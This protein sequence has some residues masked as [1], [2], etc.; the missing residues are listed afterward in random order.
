VIRLDL[1]PE[2]GKFPT[3]RHHPVPFVALFPVDER[4]ERMHWPP[5]ILGKGRGKP[6]PRLPELKFLESFFAIFCLS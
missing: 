5:L 3:H 4:E 2:K 6:Q 1:L